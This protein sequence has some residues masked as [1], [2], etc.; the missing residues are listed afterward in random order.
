MTP[1]CTARLPEARRP[2]AMESVDDLLH[3]VGLGFLGH[4]ERVDA[5]RASSAAIGRGDELGAEHGEQ[6]VVDGDDGL[7]A[8]AGMTNMFGNPAVIIPNRLAAPSAH[9][10]AM[11]TSAAADDLVAGAAGERRDLGLEAGGVDDAVELVLAARRPRRPCSVTRSIPAGQSTRVTLALLNDGRYS[12]WKQRPLAD[13]PVVRLE[14][15]RRVAGS[16]T[17]SPIRWRCSSMIP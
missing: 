3:P 4:V 7:L 14:R 13:V 9:F 15:S 12:S 6:R 8:G 2:L 1:A 10:S 17:V 11:V 16:A 5:R